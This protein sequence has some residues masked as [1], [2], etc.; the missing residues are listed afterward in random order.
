MR[1]PAL[2]AEA[3]LFVLYGAV[4]LPRVPLSLHIFEPRYLALLDYALSRPD[5]M[6]ALVQPVAPEEGARLQKVGC[7]GRVTGFLERPDGRSDITLTG[8]SRFQLAGEVAQEASWRMG[9]LEY[10]AFEADRRDGQ[11]AHF[12]RSA[13]LELVGRF[14]THQALGVELGDLV[15]A[16]DEI[17]LNV[18]SLAL[19]FS[20]EERQA[21]LECA[22]LTARQ[23]ALVALMRFAMQKDP[24]EQEVLQ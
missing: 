15:K 17:L 18:L 11:P 7:I 2:P 10:S 19:P 12:D 13:L 5:R 1:S 16:P 21:L 24:D 20:P 9:R 8:V 3:P 22:D 4:L 23:N 14:L 6:I